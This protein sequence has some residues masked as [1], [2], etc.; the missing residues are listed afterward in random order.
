MIADE[1]SDGNAMLI[2]RTI[3]MA[4]GLVWIEVPFITIHREWTEPMPDPLMD[5]KTRVRSTTIPI[6]ESRLWRR[7]ET[8]ASR[9][10]E[11]IDLSDPFLIIAAPKA[12]RNSR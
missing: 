7:K 10:V 1:G 8:V 4:P 12:M 6:L 11:N 9:L 2:P 5:G 3:I